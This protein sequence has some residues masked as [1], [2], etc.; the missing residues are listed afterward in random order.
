MKQTSALRGRHRTR[1][2][3]TEG[4]SR[5]TIR[6][7]GFPLVALLF[8]SSLG[9]QSRAARKPRSPETRLFVPRHDAGCTLGRLSAV[10]TTAKKERSR[11]TLRVRFWHRA[12]LGAGARSNRLATDSSGRSPEKLGPP[13]TGRSCVSHDPPRTMRGWTK[14]PARPQRDPA[15]RQQ[16][17]ENPRDAPKVERERG[18]WGSGPSCDG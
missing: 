12:S 5:L 14:L 4:T 7:R 11:Y 17:T 10:P 13:L 1:S 15:R 16:R 2:S 3:Q 9:R 6:G 18:F 8:P